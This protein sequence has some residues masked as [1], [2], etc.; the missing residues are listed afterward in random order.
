[1]LTDNDNSFKYQLATSG[2]SIVLICYFANVVVPEKYI[3][4]YIAKW[5]SS[6]MY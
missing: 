4:M 3:Y 5:I 6:T 1:M 2:M